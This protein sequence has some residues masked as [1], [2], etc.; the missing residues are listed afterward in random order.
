VAVLRDSTLFGQAT[1]RIIDKDNY[2]SFRSRGGSI[3]KMIQEGGESAL[4]ALRDNKTNIEQRDG[5]G[6]TPLISVLRMGKCKAAEILIKAGAKLEV[7]DVRGVTPLHWLISFQEAEIAQLATAF[8]NLPARAT[9]C[10]TT[11]EVKSSNHY[12]MVLHPGT[13]L[14]WAV[15]MRNIS[16]IKF[17]LSKKANPW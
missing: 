2:K 14:D 1:E 13:A 15:D 17:L 10:A 16:A 9:E 7:V 3:L 6:E 4:Q 8:T 12:G 11:K 5:V